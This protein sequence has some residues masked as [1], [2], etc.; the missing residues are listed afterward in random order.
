[1]SLH[2]PKEFGHVIGYANH[3]NLKISVIDLETI[4]FR[5]ANTPRGIIEFAGFT[6][7]P[8]HESGVEYSTLLDPEHNIPSQIVKLT[9][10]SNE[11]VKGKKKY[12]SQLASIVNQM[13]EEHLVVGFNHRGFDCRYL[14]D[15]H[16]IKGFKPPVFSK[17]LDV[18]S[19]ANGLLSFEKDESSS[20]TAVARKLGL[21][22]DEST[23]HRA[24]ADVKLTVEVFDA[25][26]QKFGSALSRYVV[27]LEGNQVYAK[28]VAQRSEMEG[29][30]EAVKFNQQDIFDYV[31]SGCYEGFL[32]AASD[33]QADTATLEKI[34]SDF[35]DK[36]QLDAGLFAEPEVEKIFEG[37]EK[38]NPVVLG[39]GKLKPVREEI[40]EKLGFMPSYLSVRIF[41]L[42]AGYDWNMRQKVAA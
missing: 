14:I 23:L 22:V 7:I 18:K 27:D 21:S 33:L 30:G 13:A 16:L 40:N 2:T 17:I 20:L 11:M 24:G 5:S 32:K 9:H 3:L 19:A 31:Q 8:G 25:L 28:T 12:D 37:Q 35:I 6:V 29:K 42:T 34:L 41:L 10:I 39:C 15:V 38:L 26:L 36:N 1:M 4:G